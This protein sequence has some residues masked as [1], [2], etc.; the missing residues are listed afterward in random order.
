MPYNK[1]PI[2]EQ[3]AIKYSTGLNPFDIFNTQTQQC[4]EQTAQN[5]FPK[6]LTLVKL[7]VFFA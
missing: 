3:K 2:V 1:K 4:N 5:Y 7:N 6:K